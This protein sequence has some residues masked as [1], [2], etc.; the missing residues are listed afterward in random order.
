MTIKSVGPGTTTQPSSV[1]TTQ[2]SPT[3]EVP[4]EEA[5]ALK[6]LTD[7]NDVVHCNDE[8]FQKVIEGTTSR[9]D[10]HKYLETLNGDMHARSE[11]MDQLNKQVAQLA[12]DP[13]V[14]PDIRNRVQSQLESQMHDEH[15]LIQRDGARAAE[16]M[17]ILANGA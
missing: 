4:P 8:T 13:D 1:S 11:A 2:T 5:A 7:P 12:K 16:I 17:R 15:T 9:A 14:P 6:S 3:T 10:L